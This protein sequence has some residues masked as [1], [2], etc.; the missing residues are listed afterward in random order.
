MP[1]GPERHF[2]RSNGKITGNY[3]ICFTA[4]ASGHNCRHFELIF[5]SEIHFS[6]KCWVFNIFWWFFFPSESWDVGLS[7][8]EKGGSKGGSPEAIFWFEILDF[9]QIFKKFSRFQVKIGPR[10]IPL[11]IPL[12]HF[13]KVW[14]LSFYWKKNH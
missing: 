10:V 2:T 3:C 9:S 1:L 4:I 6:V 5:A 8:N 11:L 12:F 14:H 13:W 7:K